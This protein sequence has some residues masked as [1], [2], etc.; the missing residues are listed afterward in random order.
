[1]TVDV[2]LF[3]IILCLLILFDANDKTEKKINQNKLFVRM[4]FVI[5][6][7]SIV[8][9]CAWLFNGNKTTTGIVLNYFFNYCLY[10]LNPL[11]SIL[12]VFYV[13]YQIGLKK[14]KKEFTA[15]LIPY[16]AYVLLLGLNF[17]TKAFFYVDENGLYHR[18]PYYWYT[19]F[20][21]L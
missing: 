15:L 9:S 14:S 4:L 2:N 8:D 13:R 16:I 19:L 1:M 21:Y 5:I 12:W 3:A 18:G 11:S 6:L 10:L 7:L 20:F 17:I